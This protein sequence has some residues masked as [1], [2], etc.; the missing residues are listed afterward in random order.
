MCL[1]RTIKYTMK[2]KLS[3]IPINTR[4]S[5][6]ASQKDTQLRKN[7]AKFILFPT[8]YLSVLFIDIILPAAPRPWVESASNRNEYQRYLLW[9][10]A[11]G[12]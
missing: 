3:R 2:I 11:A 8:R 4:N 10:K 6:S 5:K 9:G 12:V 7:N 1:V